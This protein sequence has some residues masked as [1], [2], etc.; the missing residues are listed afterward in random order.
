MNKSQGFLAF[1]ELHE[2]IIGEGVPQKT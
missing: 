2:T 1:S